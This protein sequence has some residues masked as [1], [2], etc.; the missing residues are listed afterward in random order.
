MSPMEIQKENVAKKTGACL[1]SCA[2]GLALLT[3]LCAGV[4]PF[5]VAVRA[6]IGAA[7]FG[8][9]GYIVA[10][11]VAHSVAHTL[12]Q[13]GKS[14]EDKG[15]EEAADDGQAGEEP[16][17]EKTPGAAQPDQQPEPAPD[18]PSAGSPT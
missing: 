3:G 15:I 11:V 10:S 6:L 8:A 1:A 14:A 2:F 16:E 7:V 13:Q 18:A 4:S 5:A 12:A 9:G 17:T